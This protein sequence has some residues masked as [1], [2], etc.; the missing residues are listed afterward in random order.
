MN[1]AGRNSALSP[2]NT[3]TVTAFEGVF[4]SHFLP[5]TPGHPATAGLE[6]SI[7][8]INNSE[9]PHFRLI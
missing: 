2:G 9:S 3:D 8:T 4:T 7:S 6:L 5:K 1:T